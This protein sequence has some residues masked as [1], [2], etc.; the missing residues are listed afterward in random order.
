MDVENHNTYSRQTG[1]LHMTQANLATY[2]KGAYY[3]GIVV[4][5]NLPTEIKDIS[6]N[7]KKYEII[8]K[9]FLYTCTFCTFDECCDT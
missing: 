8:L 9:H 5:N 3:L 1:N 7:P 4:F 6:G 2:Q